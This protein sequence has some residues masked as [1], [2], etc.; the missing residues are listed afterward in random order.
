M[1][2]IYLY[3]IINLPFS[4]YRLIQLTK[5]YKRDI[6]KIII[7]IKKKIRLLMSF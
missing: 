2:L 3:V 4:I 6:Q 1:W 7:L 5:E